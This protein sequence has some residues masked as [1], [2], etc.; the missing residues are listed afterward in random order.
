MPTWQVI[1]LGLI[2]GLTE[3]IPVSSTGHILLAG[4]F[5]GFDSPEKTF[6]VLIQLGAILAILTVYSAKLWRMAIDLPHDRRTQKFVA[7][8]VLA[9]LPAAVI[10]VAL[11][12]LIKQVLFASP[13]LICVMLIL[14]GFV[15]LAVD[16]ARLE[17]RVHE[18]MDITPWL[19]L[20]IGFFQ[21]LAMIPGV[22]RSGATIVAAMLMGTSKRAA[23]EFSFFLA[24]PTMAGAFAYDLYKT[25]AQLDAATIRGI[26]LGFV[27]SFIAGVIVVRYLLDFVSRHGFAL[28]AWWRIIL[29]GIGLG[30]LLILG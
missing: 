3:F 10:G 15:L 13:M 1:L 29:G 7:A 17:P 22:S 11:H 28:F 30:A 27:V 24:M 19:A 18:A 16:R 8:V 26:A 2:E 14:G 20:K 5:L 6:E 9:F 4:H 25:H 23:A 21:C 12:S